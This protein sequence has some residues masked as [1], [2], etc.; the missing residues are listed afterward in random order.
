MTTTSNSFRALACALAVTIAAP[1]VTLAYAAPSAADLETA[2]QLYK[3]GKELRDKGDLVGARDKF[4]AAHALGQTPITGVELGKTHMLLGELVEAREAFLS[5]GRIPVASDETKKSAEARTECD[6]LAGELKARIPTLRVILVGVPAGTSVKVTVDGEELPSAALTEARSVNPGHHT[7]IAK[8]AN[9]PESRA[10]IELK[11]SESRDATL[12]ISVTPA[13]KPLEEKHPDGTQP[14]PNPP[15]PNP[16][17]PNPPPP[18]R[19]TTPTSGG[20]TSPL[21]YIG[22]VGAGVALIAGGVTGG[23]AMGKA[24]DVK[25]QCPNNTCPTDK[26]GL[27]EDTKTYATISTVSFA[28]AAGGVVLGIIGLSKSGSSDTAIAPGVRPYIGLGSVG[29]TGAF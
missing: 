2:R 20:H 25:A 22:F 11:E 24:S 1:T 23:L 12:A 21:V 28:L 10:E 17:P 14:P 16:P 13:S 15:P 4:R 7:V 6:K 9:S 8:A 29:L 19:D 26:A 18:I 3:T 27:L 5:V